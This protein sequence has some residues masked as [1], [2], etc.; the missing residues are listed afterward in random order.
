[1]VQALLG[2]CQGEPREGVDGGAQ[3]GV[4]TSRCPEPVTVT[5]SGKG[6]LHM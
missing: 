1:M 2:A 6:S 5:L 3:E 4:S